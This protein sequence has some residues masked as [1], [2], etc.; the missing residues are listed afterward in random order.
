MKTL[1]NSRREVAE[2]ETRTCSTVKTETAES[3]YPVCHLTCTCQ[4]NHGDL[5][6]N[7]EQRCETIHSQ[8]RVQCTLTAVGKS[9]L[10]LSDD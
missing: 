9:T 7:T 6:L 2:V 10:L 1:S 4:C 8:Q 3:F 5:Y